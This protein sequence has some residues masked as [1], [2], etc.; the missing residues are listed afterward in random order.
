MSVNLDVQH[1]PL[2]G[3]YRENTAEPDV[4]PTIGQSFK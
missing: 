1:V 4:A 3:S 2:Q